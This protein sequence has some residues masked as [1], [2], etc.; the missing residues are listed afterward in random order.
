MASPSVAVA[1]QRVG[2]PTDNR[3]VG[4][5]DDGGLGTVAVGWGRRLVGGDGGWGRRAG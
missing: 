2:A 5:A 4:T 3:V 1:D